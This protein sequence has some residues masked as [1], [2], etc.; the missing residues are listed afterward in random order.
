MK[1]LCGLALLGLVLALPALTRADGPAAGTWKVT[2]LSTTGVNETTYFILKVETKQGGASAT[3]VASHPAYKNATMVEFTVKGDDVHA[4]FQ[5]GANEYTFEGRVAKDGK[6]ISGTYTLGNTVFAAYMAPTELT[7]LEAKEA[8]TSLGVPEMDKAFTLVNAGPLLRAKAQQTKD[9]DERVKLL[10]EAAEAEK[11]AAAEAPKLYREAIQKHPGT[12]AAGRAGVL[13]VANKNFEATDDEL[14]L[15]A[16]LASKSSTEFGPRYQ[17]EVAMQLSTAL[18]T[19]KQNGLAAEYASKAELLLNDKSPLDLQARVLQQLEQALKAAGRNDELKA[20]ADRMAKV[21]KLLDEDYLAKVPP[22]K[23]EPFAGRKGKSERV[24][25]VE[26]FTG[27]QCPP[28]V[29]ADVAFDGLAKTYKGT[30]VALLQYHLHIPGPDPLTNPD[31]EARAKFY[32]ISGTPTAYF[33]GTGKTVGGSNQISA[34]SAQYKRYRDILDPL[35]EEPAKVKVTATAR[36]KGDVIKINADVSGAKN[37]GQDLKLRLVLTEESIRYV[38]GNKLRFH[39]HVVRALPG[40]V[41]GVAIPEDT[42]SNKAEV[43]LGQL[44]KQW[45]AYLDDFNNK[46]PFP[47]ADRP[48]DFHHLHVVAFVQDDASKEILQA[49]QVEVT[50]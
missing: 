9:T 1:R 34:S 21:D 20:V 13:L 23:V 4:V 39:H 29:S 44:R 11:V 18:A 49:V 6:K 2:S 28:C 12:F 31:T 3:L 41:D 8:V 25:V 37:A 19:R 45:T 17:L 40:G 33:S 32:K 10:R 38:G 36:R 35:L 15:W 24:V 26:L 5:V 46:R 48:L 14:K 27:A 47:R 16:E 7:K 22:F 42:L 30:D 43:D 50:E